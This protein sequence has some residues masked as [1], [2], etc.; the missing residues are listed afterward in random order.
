MWIF[1]AFVDIRFIGLSTMSKQE[2]R[3][4]SSFWIPSWAEPTP[5]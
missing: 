3:T 2:R 4:N 1:F 5:G